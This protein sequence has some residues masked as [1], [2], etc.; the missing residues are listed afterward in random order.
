[1]LIDTHHGCISDPC[2]VPSMLIDSSAAANDGR[3]TMAS[4][5]L[6]II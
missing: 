1:V 3:S 5:S 4:N 2:H 6:N